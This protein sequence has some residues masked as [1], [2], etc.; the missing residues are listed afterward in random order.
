M[1]IEAILYY[2]VAMVLFGLFFRNI[3]APEIKRAMIILIPFVAIALSMVPWSNQVEV[4]G[5]ASVLLPEVSLSEQMA[6]PLTNT[7]NWQGILL[8]IYTL[9]LLVFLIRFARE[10]RQIAAYKKSATST[11]VYGKDV[12]VVPGLTGPFS[13]L[14]GVYL[15]K[16]EVSK[17]VVDHECLHVQLGHTWDV[18]YTKLIQVLLWWNPL[19]SKALEWLMENHEQEVDHALSAIYQEDYSQEIKIQALEQWMLSV[20]PTFSKTNQL[21]LRLTMMKK[22][23]ELTK[24]WS[25]GAIVTAVVLMAFVAV[26]TACTNEKQVQDEVEEMVTKPAPK[27]VV[28]FKELEKKPEYPGGQEALFTYL[29][30]SIVFPESL[31]RDGLSGTSFIKFVISETGKVENVEV[32][33]SFHPDA[34][35]VAV[36]VIE[37]ME[38]WIPGVKDGSNVAV[39]YTLP[40]RFQLD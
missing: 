34:D 21:K 5:M 24:A 6:Q 14:N 3:K 29:G 8:G 27:S 22:V 1:I 17:M 12:Y 39:Q 32:A 18:L 11:T 15:P 9:G 4:S 25:A 7:I 33:K 23:K 40:I 28:D 26:N 19:S 20:A 10:I 2:S 37:K 16:K 13:F 38:D 36:E 30:K 31:K 35:I